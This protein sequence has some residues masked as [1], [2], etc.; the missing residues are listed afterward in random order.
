MKLEIDHDALEVVQI[1]LVD[2][3]VDY[4]V[5]SCTLKV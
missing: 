5:N 4:D 3:D 2:S 1:D